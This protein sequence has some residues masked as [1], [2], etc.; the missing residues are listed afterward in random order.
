M[1]LKPI[2]YPITSGQTTIAE[3]LLLAE[4]AANLHVPFIQI[5]EKQLE[6]RV[7]FDL[8]TQVVQRVSGSDLKVLV[9]DRFDVALAAGAHGVHLTTHSLS[10]ETLR[11]LCGEQFIIGVST[12]ELSEV[13][14]ARDEGADFV[15][16][17]PVFE[18]ESKRGFGSSQG[19]DE[20]ARVTGAAEGFPVL[21]L[22]G[23]AQ[24]NVADCFRAGASGVAGIGMFNEVE[25]LAEVVA[26]IRGAI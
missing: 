14:R 3:V 22:G 20:L 1:M 2:I 21:A 6:T 16:F 9:N 23:V 25:R 8:V 11:R 24:E 10:A 15:V 5:R 4:T 7:L 18:T 17:G 13:I 19:L 26:K 12:H